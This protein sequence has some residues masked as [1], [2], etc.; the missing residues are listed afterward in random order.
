MLR[1]TLLAL[2]IY[3]V[4][5]LAPWA[6]LLAVNATDSSIPL[7]RSSL[8]RERR[9][10]N[11]CTWACH[12]HGCTHRPVLPEVLTGDRYLF[13]GTIRALYGVGSTLSR[14]RL[15]G[16]GAANILLLCV[17]WPALM[18]GLWVLVWRQREQL[19]A[20]RAARRNP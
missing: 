5:L 20:L 9:L 17:G 18:Y 3:V 15:R 4:P 7:A 6:L 16:Y 1:R 10:P 14:D 2:W 13:G 19:R 12:N 8:P 11:H